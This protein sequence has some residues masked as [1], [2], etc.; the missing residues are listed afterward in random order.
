MNFSFFDVIT[1]KNTSIKQMRTLKNRILNP[2]CYS[3]Y[4]DRWLQHFSKEQLIIIDGDKLKSNPINIMSQ[5]QIKLNLEPKLDYSQHLR[6][7]PKKGFYCPIDSN[8]LNNKTIATKINQTTQLTSQNKQAINLIDVLNGSYSTLANNSTSNISNKLNHTS[9]HFDSLQVKC[10][11]KSK[12]RFYPEIDLRSIKF[13]H[14]FYMKCNTM[15]F[16]L[17]VR[18]KVHVPAWLLDELS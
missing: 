11:G 13:L 9:S 4:L 18:L 2:G 12:G 17:L 14:K 7:V 5:L 15:L 6:F 3:N 8:D 10:L 1:S 16:K